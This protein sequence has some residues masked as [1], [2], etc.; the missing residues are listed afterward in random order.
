MLER[1]AADLLVLVH[2]SFILFV[3]SGGLLALRWP[4]L[5]WLHLPVVIWGALIECTGG[6]CPLTPLEN[7][8]RHLAGERGYSEDFIAQY[9]LPVIYPAEL[10]RELQ[11][12]LGSGVLLINLA[13]YGLVYLHRKR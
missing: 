12:L 3:V 9:L 8:L 4:R 2:F 13:I 6:V 7:S 10:N 5:I 11:V 1:L